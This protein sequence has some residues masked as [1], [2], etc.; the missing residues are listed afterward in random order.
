MNVSLFS[1]RDDFCYEFA[2]MCRTSG[3]PTGVIAFEQNYDVVILLYKLPGGD[4]V[5][6]A[7][8]ASVTP[9]SISG[10]EHISANL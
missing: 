9:V 8:P 6:G 5:D 10:V 2:L 4:Q 1:I 3:I 7:P